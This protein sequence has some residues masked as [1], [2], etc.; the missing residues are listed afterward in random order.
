MGTDERL[1]GG[2]TTAVLDGAG[3]TELGLGATELGIGAALEG[4]FWVSVAVTGQMVV[5]SVV[6][7]VTTMLSAGHETTV[8]A[9]LKCLCWR[10]KI[11]RLRGGRLPGDG[12]LL[13]GSDSAGG[14]G[15]GRC[16][17]G[18]GASGGAGRE[19]GSLRNG[20]EGS[21]DGDVLHFDRL[22]VF[23]GESWW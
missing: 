10:V 16:G 2:M 12:D 19:V 5:Y 7:V 20:G 4:C 6:T 22:V 8:G 15:R 17:Q 14:H 3:A 18:S 11:T 9:Q 1:T 13:G 23:R 21:D